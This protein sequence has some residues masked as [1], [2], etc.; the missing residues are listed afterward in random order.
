MISV[1]FMLSMQFI[2]MI[3][4]VVGAGLVLIVIGLLQMTKIAIFNF[5]CAL[6]MFVGWFLMVC[7]DGICE[8]TFVCGWMV[9]G[10]IVYLLCC[11]AQDG[12]T[13]KFLMMSS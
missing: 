8:S 4:L 3:L 2:G 13:L 9:I 5:I 1:L 11:E 10:S 6:L 12:G 7:S